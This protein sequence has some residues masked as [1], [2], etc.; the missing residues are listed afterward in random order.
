MIYKTSIALFLILLSLSIARAEKYVFTENWFHHK[1]QEDWQKRF[2]TF[3]NRP[4]N[5][6]EIG[7]WEGRSFFWVLNNLAINSQSTLTAIDIFSPGRFNRNLKISKAESRIKVIKG[8]SQQQLK[9]LQNESYDLI[10]IDGSHRYRDILV[11]GILAWDLLKNNGTIIFD[12]YDLEFDH[13]MPLTFESWP[14][15]D[16][17]IQAFDN[18]IGTIERINNQV[19][20]GKRETC[21]WCINLCGGV[22]DFDKRSYALGSVVKFNLN[23]KDNAEMIRLLDNKPYGMASCEFMARLAEPSFSK[24]LT[25]SSE[26]IIRRLC[27]ALLK[28]F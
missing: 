28:A 14:G 6:L 11:D 12:D 10:Y 21:T 26:K 17:F 13:Q 23:K 7:V 3:R 20:I 8:S 25:T 27:P 19:I 24:F 1:I 15:I 22:Y 2:S 18:E 9:Q 5:Y 4:I 16:A